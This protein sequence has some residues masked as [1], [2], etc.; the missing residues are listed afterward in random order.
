[1]AALFAWPGFVDRQRPTSVVGAIQ[2]VNG[3]LGFRI[4]I[5]FHK[6][7]TTRPARFAVGNYLGSGYVAVLLEQG[8]QV[9][10]C[11]FPREIA[12]VNILRHLRTFLCPSTAGKLTR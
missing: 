6:P 9:V 3:L 10:G 5:H 11:A 1:T 12:D 4:V 2:G 7:E 8:Q